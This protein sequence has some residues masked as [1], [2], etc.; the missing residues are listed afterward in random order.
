MWGV[1]WPL[2]NRGRVLYI[3]G[4]SCLELAE[5]YGTPVFVTDEGRVR[6]NYRRVRDA[7]KRFYEGVRVF[8]RYEG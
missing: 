2:E 7:F 8:L 4:C 1:E 3:G 6:E 5:R